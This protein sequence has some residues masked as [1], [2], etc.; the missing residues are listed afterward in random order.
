MHG[1]STVCDRWQKERANAQDGVS[2][3]EMD[4]QQAATR[5]DDL[6][7]LWRASVEATHSF[8]APEDIERIEGYVPQAIRSV[9][10]L[11]IAQDAAG[12]LL[13]FVGTDG[14]VIEMLFLDPQARGRGIGARLLR[15]ALD[16]YGASKLDVNEQ[17]EQA[18]GFYEHMGF[19]VVGRSEIDAMGDPFPILH[20]QLLKE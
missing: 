14:E 13:G 7:A 8:L 19:R 15:F 20:M 6:I 11:A 4:A 1:S 12:L 9:E 5:M 18:R 10:H 2:I 17:N 16:S 3:E